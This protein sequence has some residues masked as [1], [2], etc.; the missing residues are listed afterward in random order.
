MD[1]ALGYL[2]IINLDPDHIYIRL[3]FLLLVSPNRFPV[4]KAYR[5]K[6]LKLIRYLQ[7]ED[8]FKL[9]PINYNWV[10]L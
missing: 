3:N 8:S 1:Q 9:K 6:H 7:G 2:K 5:A 4:S 10:N